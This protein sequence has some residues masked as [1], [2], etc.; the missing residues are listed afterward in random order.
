[1]H[2]P[3]TAYLVSY[4]HNAFVTIGLHAPTSE[5]SRLEGSVQRLADTQNALKEA[6]DDD[7]NAG[8]ARDL[9]LVQAYEENVEV[10]CVI[11]R[12]IQQRCFN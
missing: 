2:Y 11:L 6:L 3:S 7:S 9:D 8:K 12:S 4:F 5:L 10:M 1:M